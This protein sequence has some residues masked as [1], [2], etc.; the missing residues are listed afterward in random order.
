MSSSSERDASGTD[1]FAERIKKYGMLRD[2]PQPEFSA[3]SSVYS[4]RPIGGVEAEITRATLTSAPNLASTTT[5]STSNA[6][7]TQ[8]NQ[9]S[10]IKWKY[11][12]AVVLVTMIVYFIM[13]WIQPN[14]K[15]P[16]DF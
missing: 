4:R 10:P 15:N 3:A 11:L 14:P 7:T 6:T 13:V 8:N 16:V 1:R 2:E 12:L 9:Q 5:A